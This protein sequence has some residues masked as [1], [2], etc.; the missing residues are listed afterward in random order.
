MNKQIKIA[1]FLFLSLTTL[2]TVYC[3]DADSK[4]AEDLAWQRQENGGALQRGQG[5]VQNGAPTELGEQLVAAQ[6]DIQALIKTGQLLAAFRESVRSNE[7]KNPVSVTE[8]VLKKGLDVNGIIVDENAREFQRRTLLYEAVEQNNR[9]VTYSLIQGKADVNIPAQDQSGALETP[10]EHAAKNKYDD[11]IEML[12]DSGAKVSNSPVLQQ[13]LKERDERWW[14]KEWE[15][16]KRRNRQAEEMFQRL[17]AEPKLSPRE[18]H[19]A[20]H[21]RERHVW[22]QMMGIGLEQDGERSTY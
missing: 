12:V 18:R 2:P 17:S 19:S 5:A 15:K 1:A 6:V 9:Y 10:L 21:Q 14:E 8:Q 4:E 11:I 13:Q 16:F 3:M 7:W 22:M 20:A